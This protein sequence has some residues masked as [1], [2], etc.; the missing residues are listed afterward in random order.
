LDGV[1]LSDRQIERQRLVKLGLRN[2]AQK[3]RLFLPHLLAG[4]AVEHQHSHVGIYKR[5]RGGAGRGGEE[6]GRSLARVHA[7]YTVRKEKKKK[8]KKKNVLTH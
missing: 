5:G 3:C 4:L 8:K 2:G 1:E 7:E 6:R